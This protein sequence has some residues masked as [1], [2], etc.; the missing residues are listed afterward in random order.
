MVPKEIDWRGKRTSCTPLASLGVRTYHNDQLTGILSQLL[1]YQL[2]TGQL[3]TAPSLGYSLT[4]NSSVFAVA[5]AAYLL[6][7]YHI[8]ALMP[9]VSY[10]DYSNDIHY[11]QQH[12]KAWRSAVN[13]LVSY[14][15]NSTGLIDFSLF[16]IAF[17]G[18]VSGSAINAAAVEAMIGMASVAEAVGD[19]SSYNK[20]K[21]VAISLR[22]VVN[23]AFWSDEHGIYSISASDPGNY[24]VAGLR[25]VITS[26][27]ANHTQAQLSLSHVP[28]LKL[29]P[30]YRDLSKVLSSDSSANLSPNTNGFLLQ[31]ILHQKREDLATF[32]F[33]NLWGAMVSNISRSSGASWEYVNPKLEPGL[34]QYTSLS[35]HWG[36]AT[37]YALTNYVAGIRP[38]SFGYKTWVVEPAYAGFGLD[39]VNATVPTPH[40]PLRVAK[41]VKDHLVSVSIDSPANTTGKLILGKDWACGQEIVPLR[42]SFARFGVV[43]PRILYIKWRFDHLSMMCAF[44]HVFFFCCYG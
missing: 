29:G 43:K 24:S 5:N 44:C 32:L 3:P 36:D 38:V 20:W 41:S 37:T 6:L 4:T 16:R 7:D 1:A 2:S 9:F 10:M 35:H 23:S 39:E 28:S 27:S 15:S 21:S 8:L 25:F 22:K 42:T 17:L 13:W 12:W 14:R 40:G 19:V 30:G 18:P 11:A 26:G 33:E 34:G 31:A